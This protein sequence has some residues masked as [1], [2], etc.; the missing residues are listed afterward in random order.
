MTTSEHST[1]FIICTVYADRQ[2]NDVLQNGESLDVGEFDFFCWG[3][4][5]VTVHTMVVPIIMVIIK[6]LLAHNLSIITRE[7][8]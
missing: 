7:I 8:T 6:T 2:H 3:P 5:C 4:V 1:V